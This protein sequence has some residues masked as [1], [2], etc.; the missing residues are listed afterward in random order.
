MRTLPSRQGR[1]I[2]SAAV[3]RTRA[4]LQTSHH[5]PDVGRELLQLAD[6]SRQRCRENAEVRDHDV[7]FF[8]RVHTNPSGA[9]TPPLC[10]LPGFALGRLRSAIVAPVSRVA[11][12]S[13]TYREA[14][15]GWKR[16]CSPAR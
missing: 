5:Q 12:G 2:A 4:P 14:N 16:R 1:V 11:P 8:R 15:S 10:P 6:R 9:G 3:S 13:D 7:T